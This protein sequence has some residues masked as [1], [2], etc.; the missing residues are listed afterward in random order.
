MQQT[1]IMIS[2]HIV[3]QHLQEHG[4]FKLA[5]EFSKNCSNQINKEDLV[6]IPTLENVKKHWFGHR[7]KPV[8]DSNASKRRIASGTLISLD[9]FD[10]KSPK[11]AKR[12]SNQFCAANTNDSLTSS[13]TILREETINHKLT[14][15]SSQG[16]KCFRIKDVFKSRLPDIVE[17][18]KVKPNVGN[19]LKYI[20][21]QS[22]TL[23]LKRS[24]EYN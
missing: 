2:D 20:V 22:E 13:K 7:S 16:R 18:C 11:I 9:E 10:K 15:I 8:Q 5:D 21:L 12:K 1:D 6:E 24:S 17:L 14:V 19:V 3:F 23:I 4:L